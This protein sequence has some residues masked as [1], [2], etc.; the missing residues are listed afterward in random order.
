[1][2]MDT[3]TNY[4][5]VRN[6]YAGTVNDALTCLNYM[7]ARYQNSARGQLP[8]LALIDTYRSLRTT[9]SKSEGD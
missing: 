8:R 6:N 9:N 7:R 4:G 5:G 1:M 3:K 2:R